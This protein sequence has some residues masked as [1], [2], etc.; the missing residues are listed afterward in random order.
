[1]REL[2]QFALETFG[3]VDILINN[4]GGGVIRPF[5]EHTP[6]TLRETVDRNL[7]TTLWCCYAALPH[8]QRAGYGRIQETGHHKVSLGYNHP[9]SKRTNLYADVYR[10][11]L[12]T[13]R[14]GMA[15]GINHSF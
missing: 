8:M 9:L 15:L 2:M 11:Q 7:W 5:L 4:A 6:E 13:S 12:I 10:E 14:N 3:T 1:M